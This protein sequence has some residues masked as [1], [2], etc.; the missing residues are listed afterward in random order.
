MLKNGKKLLLYL[1]G[2][3]ISGII[4]I[5]IYFLFSVIL[6]RWFDPSSTT[7]MRNERWR[8]CGF[9]FWSCQLYHKWTPYSHI[10]RHLKY[11]VIAS[12][13]NSFIY[14]DGFEF[15]A[16]KRAWQK[17]TRLGKSLLAGSTITQ[18]L[19]KNLFLTSEKN[20][21][22]KG[23]EL[24]ITTMLE[25]FLNKERIFE[26]YLNSVEWG[27]GIFGIEAAS[28]HYFHSS[29]RTLN[30]IQSAQLAAAL[31]APKCFDKRQHCKKI[32]INFNHRA[33]II[34][35]RMNTVELP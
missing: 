4:A 35:S 21:L 33:Q 23:Q 8:I 11:A 13:D 18:Q 32:R 9:N 17:N 14:H 20:Y 30:P 12:E 7:F 26:I 3:L 34:L 28:R 29:A 22:R 1:F 5:Q 15:D 19:A 2:C 10:S 24:I 31:P 16:I 6:L 27:E 25:I